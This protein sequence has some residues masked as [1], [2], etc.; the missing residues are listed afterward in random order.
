MYGELAID[1][2]GLFLDKRLYAQD[3]RCA[4]YTKKISK[5]YISDAIFLLNVLSFPNICNILESRERARKLP[6]K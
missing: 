3:G 1:G 5:F 4:K 6:Q 2:L